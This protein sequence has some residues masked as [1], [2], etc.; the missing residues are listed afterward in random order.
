M[1]AGGA[2]PVCAWSGAPVETMPAASSV[3]T[4]CCPIMD[5]PASGLLAPL[6]P[7]DAVLAADARLHLGH[8]SQ[9]DRGDLL[10]T[11]PAHA[12][13]TVVQPFEGSRQ[14]LHPVHQSVARGEGDLP[15]LVGQ[16]LVDLVREG[17][18]VADRTGE[19]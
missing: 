2:G 8:R 3:A 4:I 17:R 13:L 19:L 5:V 12:V 9:T 16:D 6:E 18:I 15:D 11:L 7:L 14:T 1:R 10:G